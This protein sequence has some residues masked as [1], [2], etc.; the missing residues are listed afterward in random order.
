[1]ALPD[2]FTTG[3]L[4]RACGGAQRL[5]QLSGAASAA[6]PAYETFVSEVKAIA[7]GD[8]YSVVGTAFNVAGE[9][10]QTAALLAQLALAC[11]AYWAHQKGAGGQEMPQGVESAYALATSKLA[12]I[13]SGGRSLGTEEDPPAA[14]EVKHV[15][16]EQGGRGWTRRT[17]G[18]FC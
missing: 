7:N 18:R 1:M 4:E 17:W 11:G 13:R 6:D 9:T 8:V 3:Q 5:V 15:D 10:T 2:L 14:L 12:E 16:M